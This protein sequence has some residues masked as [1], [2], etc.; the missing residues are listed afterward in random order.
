MQRW[1]VH[2]TSMA[3]LLCATTL[4]AGACS[5]TKHSSGG[6][7]GSAA[8]T[9]STAGSSAATG[10]AATG[11]TAGSGTA[12]QAGAQKAVDAARAVPKFVA[13]GPKFDAT[14]A[15]GKRIA[16]VPDYP[17]LPF[18]QEINSGLMPAAKAAGLTVSDCANNGTVGG[19]VQCFNQAI[20]S[21]PDAIVLNGSPSPSQL[22]PQIQAAN[23]AGIPVIAN[24]VPLDSEFP[25]GTLPPT[26]QTGLAGASLAVMMRALTLAPSVATA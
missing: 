5:S 4:L 2:K 22:Q 12:D 8:D 14:P 18:I 25:P 19:W 13:P 16:L 3:A 24:H 11:S 7:T 26:N 21:K 9:S 23:R 10:S 6:A 15:K 20:A 1:T 17:T